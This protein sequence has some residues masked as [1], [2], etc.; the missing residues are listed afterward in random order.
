MKTST[1]LIDAYNF[2]DKKVHNSAPAIFKT[3]L[4]VILKALE[5]LPQ[6]KVILVWDKA[7]YASPFI[8][9]TDS[10]SYMG[11]S[12]LKGSDSRESNESLIY[13][14]IA[15][16]QQDFIYLYT[17]NYMLSSFINKKVTVVNC[18]SDKW[19]FYD[20]Y[21]FRDKYHCEPE[22][23]RILAMLKAAVTKIYGKDMWVTVQPVMAAILFSF[24][25]IEPILSYIKEEVICVNDAKR[26]KLLS[27]VE[28]TYPII[29]NYK[30][31]NFKVYEHP[32]N[33]EQLQ[34]SI[35]RHVPEPE[36]LNYD[37][38]VSVIKPALMRKF[39]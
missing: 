22:Q 38:I 23:Y 28:T 31:V 14:Y 26:D 27:F 34:D 20:Y 6:F 7:M 15:E 4:D 33:L 8:Q 11:V 12:F 16:N 37:K 30:K 5:Q 29:W 39:G 10:L 35:S 18:H 3:L 2:V 25:D 21:T 13:S 17:K 19:A 32:Y 9:A 1:I 36:L 24:K